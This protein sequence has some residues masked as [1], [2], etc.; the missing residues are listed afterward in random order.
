[1]RG[2]SSGEVTRVVILRVAMNISRS[3]CIITKWRRSLGYE[4]EVRIIDE[5]SGL[6]KAIVK[7][8]ESGSY[9]TV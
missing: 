5:K 8:C 2:I 1:M 3:L 9:N 6:N 7:I 4:V